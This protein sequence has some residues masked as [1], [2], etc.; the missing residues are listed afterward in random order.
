MLLCDELGTALGNLSCSRGD[1]GIVL[2]VTKLSRTV[3]GSPYTSSAD[4]ACKSC[5]EAVRIP[6]KTH[7]NSSIQLRD[8]F[9]VLWNRSTNPLDWGGKR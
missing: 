2:V 9:I 4:K 1:H 5:L 7:G 8:V 3:N 6:S